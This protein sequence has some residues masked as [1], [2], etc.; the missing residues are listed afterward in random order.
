MG[1]V[2]CRTLARFHGLMK[3][4]ESRPASD[5]NVALTTKGL[6]LRNKKTNSPGAMWTMTVHAIAI[7]RFMHD[8]QALLHRIR[9]ALRA[10]LTAIGQ[11]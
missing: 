6:L 8:R 1:C 5:F 9:M 3:E 2:T 7:C 4:L 11:Q 10:G